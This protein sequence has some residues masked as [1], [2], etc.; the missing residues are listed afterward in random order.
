M[1]PALTLQ[2]ANIAIDKSTD[3]TRQKEA[4]RYSSSKADRKSCSSLR[5]G[6]TLSEYDLVHFN[7]KAGSLPRLKRTRMRHLAKPHLGV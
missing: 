3:L 2:S 5:T 6:I 1:C 7:T 4:I